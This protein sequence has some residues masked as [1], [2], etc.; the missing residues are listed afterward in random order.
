VEWTQGMFFMIWLSTFVYRWFTMTCSCFQL[1]SAIGTRSLLIAPTFWS[2]LR[3]YLILRRLVRTWNP[4]CFGTWVFFANQIF[5]SSLSRLSNFVRGSIR[6]MKDEETMTF[7]MKYDWYSLNLYWKWIKGDDFAFY[8][9]Q[10]VEIFW[11]ME[12]ISLL[13]WRNS[14]SLCHIV[15]EILWLMESISL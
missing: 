5:F 13:G 14:R 6:L 4:V 7:F 8:C 12:S 15:F 9:N 1:S 3:F 11:W 10:I 2:R